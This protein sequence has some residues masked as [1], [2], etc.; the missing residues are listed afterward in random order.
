M[1]EKNNFNLLFLNVSLHLN[2]MC[3]PENITSL[4]KHHI[5]D[6]KVT[7]HGE[8]KLVYTLPLER[9]NKFPGNRL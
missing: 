9:T 5:P 7:A 8:E 6:A 1:L 4:V 2:E 3:N